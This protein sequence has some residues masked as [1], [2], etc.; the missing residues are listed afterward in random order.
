M[1][2]APIRDPKTDHLLTPA[3][4]AMTII[5]YQPVQVNSINSMN[6]AELIDKIVVAA[7]LVSGFKIPI[8]LSTVNV[9]TGINQPTIPRLANVL[10][11]LPVYDRTS[12]NAW[13]DKEYNDAI[14]ATGRKKLI[15]AALWTEACLTFPSIDALREGYDVYVLADAVGGTSVV[16]HEMALRRIEQAG[17][18]MISIAQLACELQ[19]DWARKETAGIMVNALKHDGAFLN[20]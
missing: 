6:R 15:I 12:I 4:A 14:K 11:D 19:R 9:A 2:S 17:A 18:K 16:A 1:S 10:K 3:N 20:M 13:E 8:V 5:D 7:E